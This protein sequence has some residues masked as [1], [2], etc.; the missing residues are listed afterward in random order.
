MADIWGGGERI[1][2]WDSHWVV[3]VLDTSK[4]YQRD[5]KLTVGHMGLVLRKRE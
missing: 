3:L 4:S 2:I 5:F 1:G